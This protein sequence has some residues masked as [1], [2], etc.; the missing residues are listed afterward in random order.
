MRHQHDNTTSSD[1]TVTPHSLETN[2][3]TPPELLKSHSEVKFGAKD[4]RYTPLN[5]KQYPID[6]RTYKDHPL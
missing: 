1:I 6:N 5:T 4:T 2:I 3:N